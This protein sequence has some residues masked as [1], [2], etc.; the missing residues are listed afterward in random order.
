MKTLSRKEKLLQVAEGLKIGLE[1]DLKPPQKAWELK[2]LKSQG[3]STLGSL[4]NFSLIIGKAKSRK[5]FFINIAVSAAISKDLIL[6][7][8]RSVLPKK[9]QEVIYFDTEQGEYHVQL[10]LKRICRQ[11]GIEKPTGL[12]IYHLRTLEPSVRLKIIETVI[13]NND[14]VGMVVI[15]GVRD[16]VTSI[17]DEVQA[18]KISSKVLKW[19]EE[20]NI[21]IVTVLH[22]NKSDNNARGH[23]GTELLNKA[24]TVLSVTKMKGREEV[25]IVEPVS[26]RNKESESFAFEIIDGLPTIVENFTTK[27]SGNPKKKK[28][29]EQGCDIKN[30]LLKVVFSEEDAAFSYG[31]LVKQVKSSYQKLFNDPIGDNQVKDFIKE[32]KSKGWLLQKTVKGKYTLGLSL[33]NDP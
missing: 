22:Q 6:K 32:C 30:Q 9:Q 10:A 26:C 11:T 12:H 33:E 3:Y 24:E 14:N 15:D 4:G 17:N 27:I 21:H 20:K 5:S 23:L 31:D 13:Y 1:Q 18:T 19:S 29:V 28:L 25:S 16:L 8:Y 2:N 7:Q